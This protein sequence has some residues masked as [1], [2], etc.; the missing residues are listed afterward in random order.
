MGKNFYSTSE[1]A[2]ILKLSR[3]EVFRK[4]KSGRMRAEKV[5]RNYVIPAEAVMEA[6]GK[7]V[8]TAK[9]EEIGR[10]INRALKEYGDTFKRLAK[11]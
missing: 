2:R 9:R 8:G 4:I 6:L 10:S 5:G 1:A 3:V 7:T 11:E